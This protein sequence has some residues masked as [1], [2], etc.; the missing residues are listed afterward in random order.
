MLLLLSELEIEDNLQFPNGIHYQLDFLIFIVC[1]CGDRTKGLSL[2]CELCLLCLLCALVLHYYILS[3][4]V[5]KI[6]ASYTC[7]SNLLESFFNFV[8]VLL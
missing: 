7:K 6:I 4:F 1:V 8:S 5:G 2:L 3:L